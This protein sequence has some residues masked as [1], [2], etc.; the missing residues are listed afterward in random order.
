MSIAL[1]IGVHPWRISG[2]AGVLFELGGH[3]LKKK[4]VSAKELL[5]NL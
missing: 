3:F 5:I 2:S 1:I 4:P